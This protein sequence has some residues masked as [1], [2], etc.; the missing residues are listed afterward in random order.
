MYRSTLLLCCF[1]MIGLF[2]NAQEPVNWSPEQLMPPA[3][4]AAVI[5]SNKNLPLI[6]NIGPR[7]TIPHSVNVGMVNNKNGIASLK[8]VLSKTDRKAKVV[9]YCGCCPYEHCP[10]VRPA[11][12]TLKTM[13]FSNFYLLDLP[14]NIRKDWI[15]KGYP[16][17]N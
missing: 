5:K 9:V 17:N 8:K 2:S 11:I 6:I 16:L 1:L 10:N 13:G 4:L 15:N 3:E 12:Q 7:P 14:Q